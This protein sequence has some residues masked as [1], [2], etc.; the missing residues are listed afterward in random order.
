MIKNNLDGPLAVIALVYE[1]K[2]TIYVKWSTTT[3][4]ES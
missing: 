4:M 2:W 1:M 3:K